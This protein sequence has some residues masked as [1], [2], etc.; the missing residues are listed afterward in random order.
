MHQSEVVSI[1][2]AIQTY[3]FNDVSVNRYLYKETSKKCIN[4]SECVIGKFNELSM[5]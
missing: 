3:F 2:F 4:I 1:T 5:K